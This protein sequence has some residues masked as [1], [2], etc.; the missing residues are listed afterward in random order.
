MIVRKE[1][2]SRNVIGA[3]KQKRQMITSSSLKNKKTKN[4]KKQP[5]NGDRECHFVVKTFQ[6]QT[7][8]PF[9]NMD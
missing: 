9:T 2:F 3:T 5:Y 4:T 1:S 8:S 7:G 6:W